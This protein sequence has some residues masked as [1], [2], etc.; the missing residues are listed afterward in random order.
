ME[1]AEKTGLRTQILPFGCNLDQ[2]GGTGMKQEP[3]EDPLVLPDEWNQLMRQAEDQMEV[4][5]RQQV[6]LAFLDPGV[7]SLGLTLR[8]VAIPAGVVYEC[9]VA[10]SFAS[11]PVTA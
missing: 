7:S 8:T 3:V 6:L 11:F 2:G 1:D 5:D 9:V 10:T 4:I